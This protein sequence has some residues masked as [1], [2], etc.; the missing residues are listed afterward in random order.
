MMIEKIVGR[1]SPR[2]DGGAELLGGTRRSLLRL[3]RLLLL[4]GVA[5]P[6]SVF[7]QT[8]EARP[9]AAEAEAAISQLRSP[10]CP[11]FMLEVCPSPA[12]E[13]LRDSIYDL[14]AEGVPSDEIVEWMIANHG[15][16][17]RGLPRRSGA[18][19]LAWV[20][21]PLALLL[22][23]FGFVMWLRSSRDRKTEEAPVTA[24][25]LSEGERQ[26]LAAAMR[27]WEETGYEEP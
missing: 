12:A 16:E 7:S 4:M 23:V 10:Y 9:N 22:G 27:D 20:V 17:W 6:A 2:L 26:K 19:L 15:E 3:L 21:P 14:A 1:A 18:G 8:I 5:A 24:E 13:A 11:G 25:T